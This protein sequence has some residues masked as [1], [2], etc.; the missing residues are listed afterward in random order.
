MLTRVV[1]TAIL[2]EVIME[3]GILG[4]PGVGKT[5]IFNA[6]TSGTVVASQ[7]AQKPNVGMANV[8]DERLQQ[9]NALIATQR[10][11]Y[12]TVKFVDIAGLSKGAS[13]GGGL[14][15]KF[16]SF[17]READAVLEVVRCFESADVPHID[18]SV[19]PVRD[20]ETVETEMIFADLETLEKNIDK[21]R[22][23]A[24]T[25]T[26]KEAHIHAATLEQVIP[27]LQKGVPIRRMHLKPE[28]QKFLHTLGLVSD[29]KVLYI[30][31][32][33]ED[34]LEGTGTHAARLRAHVA[35]LGGVV[36]PV[37]AKLEAELTELPPEDRAAM[38]SEMG[39]KT[40]ALAAVT[41]AAYQLLGLQ[42]FFTVGPDEIR[43]W[44]I[45]VGFTA[46]QAAGVIHSD[47]EKGFIRAE[48]YHFK[49]LMEF[50]SEAAVK[51]AGKARAEGKNYVF[52]EG[53]IAHFLANKA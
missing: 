22:K 1:Q 38:L 43:A 49:D 28:Q 11:V 8:P 33:G 17:I 37:C 2:R 3:V 15:N 44:T 12:A 35:K 26:D 13:Q 25:G 52:Q 20:V 24:N 47:F 30:A 23:H 7:S 29:K 14:G 18:G 42:S 16:L 6:L 31:N 21:Q 40:A 4:L 10:L 50:K 45:H 19:D 41:K 46:P 48:V 27:E 34:D 5:C 39:I 9:I 32:V 36:V 51:H 53:D